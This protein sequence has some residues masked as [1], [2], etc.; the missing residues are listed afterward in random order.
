[1]DDYRT[2]S[3]FVFVPVTRSLAVS[4]EYEYFLQRDADQHLFFLRLIL[5]N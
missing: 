5:R 2:L 3:T 4:A 1:M